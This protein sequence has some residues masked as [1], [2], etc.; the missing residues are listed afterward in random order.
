MNRSVLNLCPGEDFTRLPGVG[1][2]DQEIWL[3]RR[4]SMLARVIEDNIFSAVFAH[5][6]AEYFFSDPVQTVALGLQLDERRLQSLPLLSESLDLL[7]AHESVAHPPRAE[8]ENYQDRQIENPSA[9]VF[10]AQR[11]EERDDDYHR[12]KDAEQR[13]ARLQRRG[14]LASSERFDI[15][16]DSFDLFVHLFEHDFESLEFSE[17][18]VDFS[19]LREIEGVSVAVDAK[20]RAAAGAHDSI[21]FRAELKSHAA[22]RAVGFYRIHRVLSLA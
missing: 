7:A 8:S 1:C 2:R 12:H 11:H 17:I 10:A 21:G 16:S 22:G 6:I 4:I 3:T 14:L 13:A 18:A 20:G 19:H 9:Q 15:R 5:R